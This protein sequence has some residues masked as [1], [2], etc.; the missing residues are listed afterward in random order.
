MKS[1]AFGRAICFFELACMALTKFA[2][3]GHNIM[4]DAAHP[5]G[6]KQLLIA[7]LVGL[8]AVLLGY[9]LLWPVPFDPVAGPVR[10]ANPAEKH[11][12]AVKLSPDGVPL[13]S[14]ED[15]SGHIYMMTSVLQHGDRLYLGSLLMDALGIIDAP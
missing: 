5:S 2:E 1:R 10:A 12:Y 6:K 9:L 13:V 7:G 8:S 4:S 3:K 15:D 11:S 14:L